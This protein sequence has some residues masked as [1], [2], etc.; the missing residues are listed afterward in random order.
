MP[1]WT[2]SY[3]GSNRSQSG[4]ALAVSPETANEKGSWTELIAST[5]FDA[6][7][8]QL[9]LHQNFS[10][11]G[12]IDIGIGGSGSEV[13][14]IENVLISGRSGHAQD[15]VV[16][17][18][19]PAGTR[20]SSR[21][22]TIAADTGAP[23]E[24]DV[25]VTLFGGGFTYPSGLS[26]C[27]TYGANTADS[28]GAGYDPGGS[29]G[30]YGPW[31]ELTSNTTRHIKSIAIAFGCQNELTQGFYEFITDIGI[32]ASSSETAVLEGLCWA[33]DANTDAASPGLIGP[34]PVDIPIGTRISTRSM[35][36][37]TSSTVRLFDIVLYCFY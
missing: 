10:A 29:A 24:A 23:D 14:L 1:D 26:G 27:I 20:I 3:T 18:R 16:P 9:F 7:C 36:S 21:I 17:I 31:L 8:F 34:F 22:Q 12:L 37:G 15:I 28:G 11:D 2:I 19:I 5:S 30:E 32:G 33:K 25:I 6:V 4:I 35:A 13:A